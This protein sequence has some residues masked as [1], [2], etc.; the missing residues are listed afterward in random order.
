MNLRDF[1]VKCA[2]YEPLLHVFACEVGIDSLV[3]L[4]VLRYHHYDDLDWNPC[5]CRPPSPVATRAVPF[6]CKYLVDTCSSP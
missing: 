3:V 4:Q 6:K 5:Y 1:V 2:V